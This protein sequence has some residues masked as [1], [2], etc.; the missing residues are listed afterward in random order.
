MCHVFLHSC[1]Y[2]FFA[3]NVVFVFVV[4]LQMHPPL[5]LLLFALLFFCAHWCF[6]MHPIVFTLVVPFRVWCSSS[7]Y[8][9]VATPL[10][11]C[12]CF[13]FALSLLGFALHCNSLYYPHPSFLQVRSWQSTMKQSEI[14]SNKLFF[15][16]ICLFC[17]FFKKI[18]FIC[19]CFV[20]YLVVH[21]S[22]NHMTHNEI[23][24]IWY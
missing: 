13:S 2:S 21:R 12:Y 8:S 6:S 7:R 10:H 9:S 3:L 4:A 18:C 5:L 23:R 22:K 14:F 24:A 19:K 20:S 15:H 11:V 16:F 17:L 1:Y